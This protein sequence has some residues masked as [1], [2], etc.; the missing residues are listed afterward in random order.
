MPEW[1]LYFHG[2]CFDG[3]ISGVL[4]R[5]F[6]ESEKHSIRD[7]VPVN[8]EL[9]K[10]WLSAPLK[11]P[12]AVVD[13]LYHPDAA[14]WA[15]H[16]STAFLSIGARNDFLRRRSK[17]CLLYDDTSGSC[18]S[19]LRNS[20]ASRIPDGERYREAVSWAE[21]IDTA[22]YVSADE[23]IWGDS[24]AL[25]IKQ[26]LSLE[27]ELSYYRLLLSEIRKGDLSGVAKLAP[28]AERSDEVRRRITAGYERARKD[29]HL[30]GTVAI[31]NVLLM[32]DDIVSRYVPYKVF[33]QARYSIG[34]VHCDGETRITAMRNP[35]IQFCSVPIGKILEP[36]GGGGHQRVGSVIL[37]EE[38]AQLTPT[39]VDRLLA[40][41][42]SDSSAESVIA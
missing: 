31:M 41:M 19:L 20:L 40:E 6:L 34:I 38:R 4:V 29:V 15:D 35:W 24:P 17:T 16:H 13:F 26:S 27:N 9:R 21:K 1:T 37:P 22:D 14:F 23:A 12:A 25:R 5:T 2:A 18:A 7:F 10:S 42:Q 33:P 8:Y 39:I 36:F 28:V 32:K 30:N 3:L 11:T